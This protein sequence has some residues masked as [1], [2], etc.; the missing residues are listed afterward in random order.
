M[1]CAG[2]T[3]SLQSNSHAVSGIVLAARVD[4]V[5][6]IVALAAALAGV[7][8]VVAIGLEV[9][10]C[11]D[12]ELDGRRQS[13]CALELLGGWRDDAGVANGVEELAWLAWADAVEAVWVRAVDAV[14][15]DGVLLDDCRAESWG[16]SGE[17]EAA[18]SVWSC[19]STWEDLTCCHDG[20]EAGWCHESGELHRGNDKDLYRL[21]LGYKT[22]GFE[23]T[24]FNDRRLKRTCRGLRL[25]GDQ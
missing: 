25:C 17:G 19:W 3:S 1:T 22:V 14:L 7:K 20:N 6:A 21:C 9:T 8:V 23:V 12:G 13:E 15:A 11:G 16:V 5:A 18:V 10:L 24:L 4:Q 2:I